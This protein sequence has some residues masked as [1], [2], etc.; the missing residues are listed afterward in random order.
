M[1]RVTDFDAEIA[2]LKFRIQLRLSAHQDSG[3]LLVRLRHLI[4]RKLRQEVRAR[5][6]QKKEAA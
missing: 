3:D 1:R 6:R 2:R 4:N 5:R